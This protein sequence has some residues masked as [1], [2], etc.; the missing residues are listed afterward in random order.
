MK[1]LFLAM[2]FAC[3]APCPVAAQ[4][5]QAALT[6]EQ[7]KAGFLYHFT[8]FVEWPAAVPADS[9]VLGILGGE[10]VEAELRRI[11][12]AKS[13]PGKSIIVRRLRPGDNLSG[14]H[15][16]YVG[17]GE[18]Q[19]LERA[20]AAVRGSPTLVV[21]DAAEGLERGAMINFV[22][23]DRVQFEVALESAHRGGLRLSPRLLSVA[24]RVKKSDRDRATIYAAHPRSALE[25][26]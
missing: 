14:I 10:E 5:Q 26:S 1:R 16:L 7:V 17:A 15:I 23:T 19:R 24:V 22:T 13:S 4:A 25:P 3:T 20:V 18:S 6:A 2:L 8:A 12:A 21:S 9:I 11:V